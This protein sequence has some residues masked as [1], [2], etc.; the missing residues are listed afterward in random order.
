MLLEIEDVHVHYGKIAALKGISF[1]VGEG[2]I[3][4]LIGANGAGKSTTLRS[5]NGLNR[6]REGKITFQGEDIT[7][8]PAHEIVKK[9]ISQSPEGRRVFSRMSVL[10][11]LQMGAYLNGGGAKED[12]DRVYE[13]FPRIYERR[14]QLAGTLSGGEQ[15]MVA[16]A[17]ALMTEP[18]LLLMDEPSM[19]L[20]PILVER[21]FEIIKQVHE[22]GVAVLVVEQNANV[23]LSIADR[24][25]VL[26]T[27]RIVLQGDAA[28][29]LELADLKKAYLG[30]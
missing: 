17:R 1:D 2:E 19:G 13:L 9:G 25:Y 6:P 21:S 29:L 16:M 26:Q 23:S 4:T 20:A 3:V 5:I 18:K 27:G 8:T 14:R 12:F 28:E 10:E 30:R 24:G 11:N 15:Q 7:E 22:A